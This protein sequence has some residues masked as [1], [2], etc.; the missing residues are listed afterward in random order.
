MR[1]KG[2]YSVLQLRAK[3][4]VPLECRYLS[5]S[6]TFRAET[7]REQSTPSRTQ[8]FSRRFAA[9]YA[10][11]RNS[12]RASAPSVKWLKSPEKAVAIGRLERYVADWERA[13]DQIT[14]PT[15]KPETGKKV[16]VIGSGPAGLT[17]AADIRREGHSVTVFE[18]F[19]K[20]G[21][22]MVY[23]I[24][25]FRLPKAL[26]A[27]EVENLKRMGVEFKT[28]FL[29]GR[30]A[31]LDQLLTEQGFDAAFI[32]T[33]AGLPKFMHIE[34]ENLIGVFSANEYLTRSNPTS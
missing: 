12:A 26:V 28:S 29:V 34:G 5:S 21:G 7:S 3:R 15:P 19:Q 8:T 25:E 10:L 11:R 17:V 20:T 32:G 31:T 24:P 27:K 30:T 2:A 9:A 18:A 13:N 22:V 16:A 33:G 1:L 23:G 4:A 6:S 14:V